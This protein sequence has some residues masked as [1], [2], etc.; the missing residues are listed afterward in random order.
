MRHDKD[1]VHA[2]EAHRADTLHHGADESLHEQAQRLAVQAGGDPSRLAKL[3]MVL[4][5]AARDAVLAA[6]QQLYG[7]E[8]VVRALGGGA[9]GPQRTDGVH[10]L[11]DGGDGGLVGREGKDLQPHL[12]DANKRGRYGGTFGSDRLGGGGGGGMIG[13][14]DWS[15][16]G[17]GRTSQGFEDHSGDASIDTCHPAGGD[18]APIRYPGDKAPGDGGGANFGKS[19]GNDAG[20]G[21]GAAIGSTGSNVKLERL[22]GPLPHFNSTTTPR[23]DQDAGGG[24]VIVHQGEVGQLKNSLGREL[25]GHHGTAGSANDGRGDTGGTTTTAGSST[26]MMTG[27]R[28]A[29]GGRA[30]LDHDAGGG[31]IN[32]DEVF[33]INALVNP[34]RQ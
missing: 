3:V 27:S 10:G 7:N 31:A 8:F 19:I 32:F 22:D 25:S 29:A 2:P 13:A 18:P 16:F 5:P 20:V 33:K 12:L 11:G 15:K 30:Q 6:A 4:A 24:P 1:P 21:S 28:E 26:E 9:T 34:G 23:D 14:G 17:H